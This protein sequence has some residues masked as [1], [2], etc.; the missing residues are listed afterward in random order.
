MS[1]PVPIKAGVLPTVDGERE[2]VDYLQGQ[3]ARHVETWGEAPTAAAIVLH[4][5]NG[6]ST[7]SWSI[8]ENTD[9]DGRANC[10]AAAGL[11]LE[12]ASK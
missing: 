5:K 6:Y 2:M 4:S 12:R 1:E 10:A 7:H 11:L 9:R 8:L 3:V